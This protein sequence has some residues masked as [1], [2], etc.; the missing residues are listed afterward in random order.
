MKVRLFKPN[1]G[2]QEINALKKVF[3]TGWIGIGPQTVKFENEFA[4]YV[5]T[6]NALGLNSCTAALHLAI[7]AYGFRNIEILVPT[8]TFISTAHAVVYNNCRPV[9]VDVDPKTLCVD[10]NDA[11]RK[12]TAK[13]RAI[14]PVHL[15]GQPCDME[16]MMVFAKKH[17]LIVIEDVANAA[18]G[19]FNG[20]ELGSWGS[21]GCFSFEAKKNMTTGDGGMITSNDIKRIKYLRKIRWLGIDKDTWKRFSS[22]KKGKQVYSWYYE[23]N[24]L[25]YKYN[26]N[27][28]Q[29]TIGLVQ[30]SKLDAINAAKRKIIKKYLSLLSKCELV[31][32]PNC[33]DLKKGAYWLFIVRC[34]YR[35]ALIKYLS[36]KGVT[37][38][39]HFMPV[40]LHP[41]YRKFHANLPVAERVWKEIVSLPLYSSLKNKE[42]EHVVDSIKSFEK[43]FRR[44]KI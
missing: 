20:K 21:M 9:F 33:L 31:K 24:D 18:G 23:I 6:R 37:T 4:N 38:G 44:G 1:L 10:I 2:N 22:Q 5:G 32:V 26:M 7:L 13:T 43:D 34:K 42:I 36:K 15:G 35:D 3:K 29:A 16:R 11:E 12:I 8:I 28:I 39:V 27:D 17:K 25:G 14:I 41:Y 40:H 30:L 19:Q